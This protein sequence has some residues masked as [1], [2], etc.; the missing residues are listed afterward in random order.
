MNYRNLPDLLTLARIG[1]T[2][3]RRPCGDIRR[4]LGEERDELVAAL[5]DGDI[6][7]IL[8]EAG[9]VAYYTALARANGCRRVVGFLTRADL[10]RLADALQPA[11]PGIT[12]EAAYHAAVLAAR[13]K[14]HARFVEND[15]AKKPRAERAAIMAA[16][17]AWWRDVSA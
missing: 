5:Q 15:R 6:A 14:Y 8:E 11:L 13:A 12:P 10:R 17:R 3:L 16:V 7:A 2:G 1:P 4:R 9:D